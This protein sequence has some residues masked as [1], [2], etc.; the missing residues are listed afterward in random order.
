VGR[1]EA[2]GRARRH[3]LARALRIDKLCLAALD[4]TLRLYRE[5]ARAAQEIPVLAMLLADP[6][7]LRDRAQR[8]ADG[9]RAAGAAAQVVEAS[10]RV[11]GGAL[12][13]LELR[14][15]A[16]AVDPSATGI[17]VDALAARL[18]GGSPPL[19]GRIRGG[20]LLLGPRTMTEAEVG[21]AAEVVAAAL[22]A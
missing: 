22:G 14:G 1:E 4:A 6:A 20:E 18:R 9:L 12:P 21:A 10:A 15:P 13:L 16:V 19:V 8:L 3:P 2:V 5:P 7:A 17:G 11:G